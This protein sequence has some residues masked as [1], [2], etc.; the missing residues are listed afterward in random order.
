M[1]KQVGVILAGENYVLHFVILLIVNYTA[2]NIE[3]KDST[4]L[5]VKVGAPCIMYHGGMCECPPPPIGQFAT[6][7]PVLLS[8]SYSYKK[9]I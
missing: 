7:L 9:N 5:F 1:P 6:S 3:C 8:F 2:T 4:N